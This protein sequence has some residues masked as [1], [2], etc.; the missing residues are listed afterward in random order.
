[1]RK[2]SKKHISLFDKAISHIVILAFIVFLSFPFFMMLATAFKPY[3]DIIMWPPKILP[4]TIR[5]ENFIEAWG[6]SYN[7]KIGFLNSLVISISTMVLCILIGSI[8]AYA[9]ARF[10]FVGKKAFLFIMLATQMFAPVV[11]IVPMYNVMNKL[12]LLN[13]YI[14][15]I[16]P[17]TAFSLPMCIWMLS[18]FLKEISPNLE[19]AAMI[20]GCTRI[21]AIFK[22]I[23]PICA[24]AIVSVGIFAFINA[25]NDVLFS[26]IFITKPN[27]RPITLMLLDFKSQYQVHWNLLMAGAVIA[28]IPITA[29]FISIQKYLVKGLT[30]GGIKE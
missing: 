27:M 26:M 6:S 1:M 16:L 24:P 25:W 7:L 30:S 20:D 2:G 15:L 18:S 5:L 8:A 11:L 14:S 22:V 19:E 4:T 10:D 29:L 17:N 3:E 28:V 9:L 12:G 23:F 21:Q 13:T